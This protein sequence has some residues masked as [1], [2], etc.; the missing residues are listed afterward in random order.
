MNGVS[1]LSVFTI[2]T[3]PKYISELAEDRIW[4]TKPRPGFLEKLVVGFRCFFLLC[5]AALKDSRPLESNPTLS[6][7][8]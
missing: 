4:V 5:K 6:T 7:V 2:L 8:D 1:F 3:L